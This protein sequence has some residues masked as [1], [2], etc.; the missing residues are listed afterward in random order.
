MA[1]QL[2]PAQERVLRDLFDRG[3]PRPAVDPALAPQLRA[4]LHE[5]IGGAVET[6]Q[7]AERQLFVNKHAIS[8]VLGCEERWM[9]DTEFVWS[10]RTAV[11]SIAHKAAELV[12]VGKLAGSPAR[13]VDAA[14]EV[15][16][17]DQPFGDFARFLQLASDGERAELRSRAVTIVTSLTDAFPPIG[18]GWQARAEQLFRTAVGQ[19]SVTLSARPDLAFG[20]PVGPE[21]RTLLIDFKAGLPSQTDLDD[22]R[23]YAL[24]HTLVYGV[25]PWRVI[26]FYLAEATWM[27]EDI[28]ADV[29]HAAVRRTSDAIDKMAATLCGGRVAVLTPSPACRWCGVREACPGSREWDE[30]GDGADDPDADLDRMAF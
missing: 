9:R 26:T 27:G 18:P 12:L 7:L 8:T 22:G 6:L 5:R 14:I 19:R 1:E 24:V 21:A 17:N 11:G 16:C 29:L 28:D 23:F 13:A 4:E 3:G 30:R 15:A 10:T 25:A 20:R 2:N